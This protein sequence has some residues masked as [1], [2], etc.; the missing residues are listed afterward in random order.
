MFVDRFG[1]FLVILELF[2]YFL[3]QST[4]QFTAD[5]VNSWNQLNVSFGDILVMFCISLI[6]LASWTFLR[7]FSQNQQIKFY[8]LIS[9]NKLNTTFWVFNRKIEK[10]IFLQKQYFFVL[11]RGWI[12]VFFGGQLMQLLDSASCFPRALCYTFLP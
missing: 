8:Q 10:S 1:I 11:C 3:S 4:D 7:I 12:L 6:F 9:W 5:Q 2:E